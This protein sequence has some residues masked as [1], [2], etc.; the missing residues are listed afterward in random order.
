MTAGALELRVNGHEFAFEPSQT[1]CPECGK[2][3]GYRNGVDVTTDEAETAV[4]VTFRC[5]ACD[6]DVET[7]SR[8]VKGSPSAAPDEGSDAQAVIEWIEEYA[9]TEGR[10]PSKSKCVQDLPFEVFEAQELL[11]ELL[12]EEKIEEVEELRAGGKIT[13]YKPV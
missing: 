5:A 9:E 3:M 7:V 6:V 2:E 10:H 11:T 4:T 13:V 1:A 12:A 8:T